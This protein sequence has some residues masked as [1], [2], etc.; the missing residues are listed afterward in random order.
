[1]DGHLTERA[2]YLTK[3]AR[4]VVDEGRGECPTSVVATF[5][6]NLESLGFTLSRALFER[7]RTRTAEEVAGLYGEVVPILE[8]MI[9]AH[10]QFRPMY[11]GFPA[12]VMA[13]S[14]LELYVNAMA[15]YWGSFVADVTGRPGYVILP[16]YPEAERE[17]LREEVRLR[18]IDLGTKEDFE[19]ILTALVGSNGSLSEADKGIVAWFVETYGDGL[20]RLLPREIPQKE[21]L[22]LLAGC[23]LKRS[24]PTYLLPHLKTATDVLRVAVVLSGGDVSLASPTKFR[25][26]SRRERRFLLRAL[27][28]CGE[29]TG[30]MLRWD[31]YWTRL[32]EILH[33][34]EY[35]ARYPKVHEAFDVVRN[36]LPFATYDA[37]VEA[38]LRGAD[39]PGV[40]DLLRQ[41][42][43]VFARRLDHLLRLGGGSAAV[44]AFLGG[45]ERV[46]T[47]VLL[48]VFHHFKGRSEEHDLRTFF[49]KG[50]VAKVQVLE[51]SLPPLPGDL[52]AAVA[53][54]VRSA[55]V[56]RFR[57]LPPLGKVWVD[58]ALDRYPV[59]FAQ[60]SASKSLRT[61]ARGSRIDLPKGETIR[62]FLWWKNGEHRTDIDLSAVFFAGDWTRRGHI[63][64]FQLREDT[65]GCCHSGDIVDAPEGACEFIDMDTRAMLADGCR[66]AVM[67]LNSFTRQPY[68]DLPECFAGWM[69]R[70]HP[71]SGEAFEARTVQDKIDLASDTTVSIP[72]VLDLE[73]RRVIWADVAL[74]SARRINNVNANGDN[75]ARLARAMVELDRPNLRDLFLMHSEAR[76]ILSPRDGA[77]AVFSVGEGVTP[78]DGDKILSE[79]LL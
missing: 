46:A 52:T 30:D 48:Q 70:E 3:R 12:Q 10:R 9:G 59:P 33:P 44:E 18:V 13:A 65:F 22:A 24:E 16:R 1:M 23:L 15:H 21:S 34:S 56:R 67:C 26:F 19:A 77:D 62:F 25:K 40:V 4:V 29:I 63:A 39:I 45:A 6:K 36:R 78:F 60:R 71:Q 57:A 54:G 37:K 58:D 7:L 73:G 11:P 42:P 14:E 64:Y 47:P 74:K 68:C 41:R 20:V 27:E 75:L 31:G 69:A 5:N 66:Y 53:D 2:I 28:E 72:V 51:G 61:V 8:E 43:G 32:G 50:D 79:F 55:L 35:K 17:P 49:P 38:G 76:G